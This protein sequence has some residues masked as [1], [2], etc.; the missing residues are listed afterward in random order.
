MI[1]GAAA[2]E[3][4]GLLRRH[5]FDGIAEI[6]RMVATDRRDDGRRRTI[7]HVGGVDT[8]TE[9]HFEQEHVRRS[10][11][12][13]EEGRSRGDLEHGDRFA[14]IRGLAARQGVGQL[15]LG[16]VAAAAHRADADTLVE[17]HEMR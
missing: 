14:G 5:R 8:P 2:F 15:V 13:Q 17:S 12:E 7:D 3:D 4:A 11:R 10:F 9:A 16:H 6:F 1:A